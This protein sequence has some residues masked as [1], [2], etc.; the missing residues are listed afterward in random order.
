MCLLLVS[1]SVP[2]FSSTV[3]CLL[4]FLTLYL[5]G[6]GKFTIPDFEWPTARRVSNFWVQTFF[7]NPCLCIES[8]LRPFWGN[9]DEFHGG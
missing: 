9:F 8:K 4:A 5:P 7:V 2:D 6:G 3:A 1:V